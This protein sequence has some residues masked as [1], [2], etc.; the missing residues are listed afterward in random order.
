MAKRG[1]LTAPVL[2]GV[3]FG[4][5]SSAVF[6]WWVN[7]EEPLVIQYSGSTT[8]TGSDTT[9]TSLVP[10]L[11]LRLGDR[12]IP[13]IYTH[14]ITFSRH[15][16]YADSVDIAITFEREP[17]IFG[18]GVTPP[19]PVHN[20]ECGTITSGLKCR[21]GPV[22]GQGEYTVALATDIQTPPTLS[23]AGKE[24]R[25][26]SYR[27]LRTEEQSWRNPMTIAKYVLLIALYITL[28]FYSS[29]FERLFTSSPTPA[30]LEKK[31]AALQAQLEKAKSQS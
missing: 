29:L 30:R 10:G 13:A 20:I 5:L 15:S 19:S 4:G 6:T 12:H 1:W 3:L 25:V 7:R 24:A 23:I 26:A 14:V 31:I 28:V 8:G 9:T 11:A 18:S 17:E 22:D 27:E 21:F 2:V 16:G